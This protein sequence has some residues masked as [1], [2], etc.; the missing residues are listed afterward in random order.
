MAKKESSLPAGFTP[1]GFEKVD[2][3]YTTEV[4]NVLQG[5]LQGSFKVTT[6]L[7]VKKVF[8]IKLTKGGTIVQNDNKEPATLAVGDVCGIDQ[9][10][11]LKP[12]DDVKEGQ[13][14]YIQC[15]GKGT[16]KKGQSAPWTF[17]VG[18]KA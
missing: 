1:L 6:D 2:G 9:R 12:L 3:W 10:G 7:G 5:I 15:T 11:F 13:E 14:V 17:V 18:A 8:R 16:A 4:G